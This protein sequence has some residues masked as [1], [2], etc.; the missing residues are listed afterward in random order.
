MLAPEQRPELALLSP[1]P[2]QQWSQSHR[3]FDLGFQ[4]EAEELDCLLLLFEIHPK[5][6]SISAVSFCLLDAS[7][8]RTS[9]SL[10]HIWERINLQCTLWRNISL[11]KKNADW[12]FNVPNLVRTSYH[13][14]S[15][16]RS[17]YMSIK[18]VCNC[19]VVHRILLLATAFGK[20]R[21][22]FLETKWSHWLPNRE[23][24]TRRKRDCSGPGFKN[25]PMHISFSFGGQGY[26]F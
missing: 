25:T 13:C 19:F 22:Q 26:F 7:L 8:R 18:F 5:E 23:L 6:H 2:K 14:E 20:G 15:L 3:K 21:G 16:E 17:K 9:L 24:K 1:L 4:N 10:Q 12:N 11:K